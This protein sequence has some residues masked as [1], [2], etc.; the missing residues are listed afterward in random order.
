MPRWSWRACAATIPTPNSP[1]D[2]G[3]GF[4]TVYRCIREAAEVLAVVTLPAEIRDGVVAVILAYD[5]QLVT[6]G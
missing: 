5:T 6:T 4:A 2:S 1:A 3:P